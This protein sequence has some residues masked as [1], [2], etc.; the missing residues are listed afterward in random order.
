MAFGLQSL[1][2]VDL[3]HVSQ[4]KAMVMR[5]ILAQATLVQ[6]HLA[7]AG[8]PVSSLFFL[9]AARF[10]VSAQFF[11]SRVEFRLHEGL[12]REILEALFS[13]PRK[14][15]QQ[16]SRRQSEQ[17]MATSAAQEQAE[18]GSEDREDAQSPTVGEPGDIGD[19]SSSATEPWPNFPGRHVGRCT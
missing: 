13:S 14:S 9:P 10:C 11:F 6:G 4:V 17:G 2:L 12:A 19:H 18:E 16:Q 15:P 7:H 8:G 3:V 5:S 1:D